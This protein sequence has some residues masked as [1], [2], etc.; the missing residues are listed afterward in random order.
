M[1]S[2]V[3]QVAKRRE[4]EPAKIEKV[5]VYE[6]HLPVSSRGLACLERQDVLIEEMHFFKRSSRGE[7]FENERVPYKRNLI[8][9]RKHGLSVGIRTPK[10]ETTNLHVFGYRDIRDLLNDLGI[11]QDSLNSARGREVVAYRSDAALYGLRV[12]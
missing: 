3:K 8:S 7:G 11:T 2:L 10:D 9:Q 6:G 5:K 1:V 12:N 4:G